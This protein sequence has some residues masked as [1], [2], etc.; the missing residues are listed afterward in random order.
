MPTNDTKMPEDAIERL[1]R[2]IHADYLGK[3]RKAGNTGLPSAV[4]WDAL[5]DE[6]KESNRAAARSFEKK[7]TL[8]GYDIAPAGS[9]RPAIET[10]DDATLLALSKAEHDRWMSEKLANGWTCAPVRDNAR[11]HHPMLIPFDQLPP[12]EQQKDTNVVN[13]IIPLLKSI[14]LGVYNSNP[15]SN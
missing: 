1:A 2:Q 13:T 14:G 7:L 6:F 8:A 9:P 5:P 4:E 3:M 15:Q 10:F 11:K 12:E